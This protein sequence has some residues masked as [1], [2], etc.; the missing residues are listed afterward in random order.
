MFNLPDFDPNKQTGANSNPVLTRT[1]SGKSLRSLVDEKVAETIPEHLP[2]EGN[3][4]KQ[5]LIHNGKV[6]KIVK[7]SDSKEKD[8]VKKEASGRGLF[9]KRSTSN[10]KEE[11]TIYQ[12]PVFNHYSSFNLESSHSQGLSRKSP[13]SMTEQSPHQ[14]PEKKSPKD[15]YAFRQSL[16]GSSFNPMSNANSIKKSPS[17][18]SLTNRSPYDVKTTPRTPSQQ[19]TLEKMEEIGKNIESFAKKFQDQI[20]F[21]KNQKQNALNSGNEKDWVANESEIIQS[22]ILQ[23][24]DQLGTEWHTTLRPEMTTIM[25]QQKLEEESRAF[26]KIDFKSLGFAP[27]PTSGIREQLPSLSPKKSPKLDKHLQVAY[28]YLKDLMLEPSSSTVGSFFDFKVKTNSKK[29]MNLLSHKELKEDNFTLL[30]CYIEGLINLGLLLRREGSKL[31]QGKYDQPYAQIA[32][33][34]EDKIESIAKK[35]KKINTIERQAIINQC[36]YEMGDCCLQY[37]RQLKDMQLKQVSDAATN[38]IEFMQTKTKYLEQEGIFRISATKVD[39]DQTL[40]ALLKSPQKNIAEF[41]DDVHMLACT[42]KELIGRMELFKESNLESAYVQTAK[43][44]SEEKDKEQIITKLK[45]L[46]LLLSDN[47]RNDLKKLLDFFWHVS[48]HS[49]KNKMTITNLTICLAQRLCQPKNT[50]NDPMDVVALT[51]PLNHLLTQLIVYRDDVFS[52]T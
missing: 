8:E 19:I 48:Q 15:H 6:I 16:M 47:Q 49:E 22:L 13:S 37:A 42:L 29:L 44:I 25:S 38:L 32:Q 39:V 11:M 7:K 14:T 17:S 1:S 28:E 30:S 40:D 4:T 23:L 2:T 18:H 20:D 52:T 46:V 41:K 34:F 50:S 21:I 9:R 10:V 12:N 24:R 5:P 36:C 33:S 27:S 31:G 45:A 51:E 26:S 43:E 3:S 35:A